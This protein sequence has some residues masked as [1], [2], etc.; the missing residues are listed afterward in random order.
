MA[1]A[2]EGRKVSRARSHL[3][4]SAYKYFIELRTSHIQHRSDVQ[5]YLIYSTD[6]MYSYISY[7]AQI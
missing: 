6:Q 7:T 4:E 5:L 2:V 3:L 1:D